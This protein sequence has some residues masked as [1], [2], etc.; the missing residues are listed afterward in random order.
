MSEEL[1]DVRQVQAYLKVSERTVFNLIK[2][3]E[4]TG[5]KAGR[6]WRF[7]LADVQDYENR[8]RQK[9]QEEVAK[10]SRKSE[11]AA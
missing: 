6:E 2:R 10:R 11:E 1:L 7:S 9:A 3:G 4:L 5:F 8:Q